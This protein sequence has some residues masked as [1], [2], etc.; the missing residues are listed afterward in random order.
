MNKSVSGILAVFGFMNWNFP[1]SNGFFFAA[2]T[3]SVGDGR[4][5][6]AIFMVGAAIVWF[7]PPR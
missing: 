7:L 3:M 4:I 2:D 1:G 5:V 6:G